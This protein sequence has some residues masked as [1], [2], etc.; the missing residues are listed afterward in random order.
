[1]A[2]FLPHVDQESDSFQEINWNTWDS[3]IASL[4]WKVST[5]ELQ[6][7]LRAFIIIDMRV[8]KRR[9][10]FKQLCLMDVEVDKWL[11]LDNFI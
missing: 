9:K 5:L 10:C 11:A 3:A 6:G 4:N 1:V 2:G 8:W 7:V